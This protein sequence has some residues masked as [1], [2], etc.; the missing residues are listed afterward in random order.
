MGVGSDV[1]CGCDGDIEPRPTDTV[2]L[3]VLN[4]CCKWSGNNSEE[5]NARIVFLVAAF[6]ADD[7]E[8]GF[9]KNVWRTYR[10]RK[11][12][13]REREKNLSEV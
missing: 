2:K 8:E 12:L 1:G 7:V 4:F 3:D 11:K 5:I 6:C 10:D 9:P 13:E